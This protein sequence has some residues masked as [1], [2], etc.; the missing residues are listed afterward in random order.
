MGL[1]DRADRDLHADD[2]VEEGASGKAQT[3]LLSDLARVLGKLELALAEEDLLVGTLGV[4]AHGGE[5]LLIDRLALVRSSE[6]D[7]QLVEDDGQVHLDL[8]T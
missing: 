7:R 1:I 5:L 3:H 2:A 4:E 8:A 6:K